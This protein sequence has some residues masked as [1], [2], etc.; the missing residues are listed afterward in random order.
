MNDSAQSHERVEGDPPT[1]GRFES[2]LACVLDALNR[3]ENPLTANEIAK[4]T[5]CA[6]VTVR[7]HLGN[8]R[9]DGQVCVAGQRARQGADG[10]RLPSRRPNLYSLAAS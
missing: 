10:H 2:R 8:L 6:L 9:K 7:R 3:A 4:E 5:G 1:P